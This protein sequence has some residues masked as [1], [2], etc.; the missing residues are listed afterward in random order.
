MIFKPDLVVYSPMEELQLVVEVKTKRGASDEW[1]SRLRRN[2]IA[3]SI[4][5]KAKFFLLA[6]P[7]YLWLWRDTHTANDVPADFK[8]PTR[9]VLGPYLHY[10]PQDFPT[11]STF[12]LLVKSWLSDL[13]NTHLSKETVPPELR[14]LFDS[15]LY[16][17]IRFGNVERET[18]A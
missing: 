2:L 15:G 17:S 3:H 1:A 4:V 5:P 13:T 10:W 6:L 16:E 11:E 8:V 18:F 12:E 9:D 7:E 14:W